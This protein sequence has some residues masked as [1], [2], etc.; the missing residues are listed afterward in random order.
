MEEDHKDIACESALLDYETKSSEPQVDFNFGGIDFGYP[1]TL[2]EVNAALDK[3]DAERQD[4]E[5]WTTAIEFHNRL[6]Q[7]YPWLR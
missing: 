3:A 4:P 2:E 6:E 5:K 1:R 7:K